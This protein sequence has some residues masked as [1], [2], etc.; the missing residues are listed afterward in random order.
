MPGSPQQRQ[1]NQNRDGV[2]VILQAFSE[3]AIVDVRLSAC[4]IRA[5]LRSRRLL[6]HAAAARLDV[7]PASLADLASGL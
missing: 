5:V 3:A 1:V 2:A 4:G 6:P 7:H